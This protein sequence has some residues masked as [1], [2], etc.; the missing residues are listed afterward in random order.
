MAASPAARC[1]GSESKLLFLLQYVAKNSSELHQR[2]AAKRLPV[3]AEVDDHDDEV[4]RRLRTLP[5]P[6]PAPAA[7]APSAA[8]AFEAASSSVAV[9][10]APASG[11]AAASGETP[12]VHE[13]SEEA[14]EARLDKQWKQ[15]KLEVND[16]P[17]V[18]AR[19][20]KIKLTGSDAQPRA[21]RKAA[22]HVAPPTFCNLSVCLV[23]HL[24][25][26]QQRTKLLILPID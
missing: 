20:S 24:I 1:D 17:G 11:G 10:D 9:M 4:A 26:K 12:H 14:R 13:E 15:L 5:P 18:Y 2:A 8:A 19:L 21:N 16:L 7:A 3:P 25:G 6:G 23:G 22:L